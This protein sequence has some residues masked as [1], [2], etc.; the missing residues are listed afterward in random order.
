MGCSSSKRARIV[1][2]RSELPSLLRSRSAPGRATTRRKTCGAATGI[3]SL[4]IEHGHLHLKE[5][6]TD[7]AMEEEEQL[8]RGTPENRWRSDLSFE[9]FP[10]KTWSAMVESKLAGVPRSPT[11][12]AAVLTPPAAEEMVAPEIVNAWEL[13]ESL[14][15]SSS[16]SSSSGDTSS[17]RGTTPGSWAMERLMVRA[18]SPE[19]KSQPAV[20]SL[21]HSPGSSRLSDPPVAGK[22]DGLAGEGGDV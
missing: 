5:P 21:H 19:Y 16:S 7:Q 15:D 14:E 6:T 20:G 9:V 17:G 3:T 22:R 10:A 18:P 1:Q 11:E 2:R 8:R 12:S 4:G 13:M